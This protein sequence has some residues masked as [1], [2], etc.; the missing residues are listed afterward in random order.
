[1]GNNDESKLCRLKLAMNKHGS[2]VMLAEVESDFA[3]IMVSFLTRPIGAIL[4]SLQHHYRDKPPRIGS[5][6]T[7]YN[8]LASLSIDHFVTEL[9][10]EMVVNPRSPFEPEY[11]KMKLHI[12]C[13]DDKYFTC[14]NWTCPYPRYSNISMYYDVQKCRCGKNLNRAVGFNEEE[15]SEAS[16][17]FM[18]SSASFV[19]SDDLRLLPND[20]VLSVV[21]TLRRL[22]IVG[23]DEFEL[24]D[25][26]IGYNEVIDF[27]S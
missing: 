24:R 11:R 26:N 2:K 16:G 7:L 10:K 27:N 25:V 17:V 21:G 8:S 20:G 18:S 14:E 13:D 15:D 19:I 5:L 4:R 22:G 1:M 9:A 23:I 12:G 3:D 6:T